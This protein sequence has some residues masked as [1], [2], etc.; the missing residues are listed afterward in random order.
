MK[1]ISYPNIRKLIGS[2]NLLLTYFEETIGAKGSMNYTMA[3]LI[4][5]FVK[6][7]A[8]PFPG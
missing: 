4:S 6:S 3:F 1:S 8:F 7:T 2:E 5:Y